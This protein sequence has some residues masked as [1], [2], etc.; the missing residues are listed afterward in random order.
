MKKIYESD[1]LCIELD[2]IL[3][4]IN[5]TIKPESEKMTEIIFKKETLI[6]SG[7][8]LKYKIK[9]LLVDGRNFRFVVTPD[10]Q[11]WLD[12]NL[13]YP[14]INSG[15]KRYA[16]VIPQGIFVAIAIEQTSPQNTPEDFSYK[17]T[18]DYNEALNWI[19]K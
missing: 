9:R 13:T 12:N 19:M 6:W 11:K 17:L 8:M 16:N 1:F 18:P 2:E 14:A 7:F 3:S 4:F 15:L 10:L 5:I